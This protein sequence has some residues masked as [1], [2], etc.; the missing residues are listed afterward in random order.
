MVRANDPDNYAEAIEKFREYWG[1]KAQARFRET[2]YTGKYRARKDVSM[3]DYPLN[4]ARQTRTLEPPM[5]EEE[6]IRAIKR[7]FTRD[8][9]REI[10]ATTIGSLADLFAFLDA[11]ENKKS[12]KRSEP[13]VKRGS[14]S[15]AIIAR[16]NIPRYP[17]YERTYDKAER[18][19]YD[20]Y[21]PTVAS[22]VVK[23]RWRLRV[24]Q[25]SGYMR[26]ATHD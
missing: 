7:H 1:D 18:I 12:M 26:C 21:N 15:R 25:T 8:I 5:T 14:T 6:V 16:P 2:I 20:N 23:V 4:V 17:N 11:I 22:Y 24:K 10:R 9:S 3:A 19:R 13:D